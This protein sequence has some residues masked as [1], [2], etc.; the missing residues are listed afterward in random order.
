MKQQCDSIH[1]EYQ[2]RQHEILMNGLFQLCKNQKI[3]VYLTYSLS[4]HKKQLLNAYHMPKTI[5]NVGDK[6]RNQQTHSD[7]MD[8]T[9][10]WLVQKQKEK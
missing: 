1:V 7:F 2:S 9:F 10:Q 3:D 5:L 8:P 4:T 6:T